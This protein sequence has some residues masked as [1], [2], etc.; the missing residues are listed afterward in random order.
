M[1]VLAFFAVAG[2]A[3]LA[4][5]FVAD[6]TLE[7][8]SSPIVTSSRIGLPEQRRPD[9]IQVLTTTR[10]PAPDMTSQPV[11]AAQPKSDIEPLAKIT[12]ATRDEMLQR[13]VGYGQH[14]PGD[15]LSIKGQ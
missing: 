5:L 9:T 1:P 8:R 14:R 11:L 4:L 12:P 6:A 13:L 10:A 3:L 15:N 7:K 2:L